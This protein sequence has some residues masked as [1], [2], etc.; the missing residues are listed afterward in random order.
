MIGALR[1]IALFIFSCG[2]AFAATMF[3]RHEHGWAYGIGGGFLA[4]LLLIVMSIFISARAGES[5]EDISGVDL[6]LP[7]LLSVFAGIVF[8]PIGAVF[9]NLFSVFT[10]IGSGLLLSGSLLAY[11]HDHLHGAFLT[12]PYLTF[13]YEILP[14]DF[15]TDLDNVIGFG[16]SAVSLLIG[17]LVHP[18]PEITEK[19]D[20][21]EVVEE[22]EV[23]EEPPRKRSAKR[24]QSSARLR[25]Q[26]SSKKHTLKK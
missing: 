9:G 25:L 24:L 8:F 10:C 17:K 12:L 23:I 4:F 2:G 3:F 19:R 6:V 21:P 13:F 14:V 5:R 18:S 22:F 26:T 1:F 16:G 20:T 15:P 7:I 11:K